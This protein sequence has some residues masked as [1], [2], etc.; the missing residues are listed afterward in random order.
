[1]SWIKSTKLV[2]YRGKQEN[3]INLNNSIIYRRG[4]LC[5]IGD[6]GNDGMVQVKLK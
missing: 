1:M 6:I 5:T 2:L 4:T 3:N